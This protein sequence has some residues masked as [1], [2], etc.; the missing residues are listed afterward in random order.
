M[1]ELGIDI[2]ASDVIAVVLDGTH[3]DAV[4]EKL[5]PTRIPCHKLALTK[6]T[7]CSF[8]KIN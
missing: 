4:I 6:Q 2:Q 7:V 5:E 8:S 3:T 1:R